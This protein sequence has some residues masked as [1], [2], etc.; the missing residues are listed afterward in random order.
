MGLAEG[1]NNDWRADRI[2]L[3]IKAPDEIKSHPALYN[4]SIAEVFS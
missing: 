1:E 4:S 2:N 3:Q